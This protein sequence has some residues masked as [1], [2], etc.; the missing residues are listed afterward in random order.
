MAF[1]DDGRPVL[2]ALLMRRALE[3]AGMLGL[4]IIDHCEDPSLKGEGVAHEGFQAAALGLRGI[5]G[6]AES[7][8][9]E[10]DVSLAE[11][12]GAPVHVAHMSARQSIRAVRAGKERG[13]RVTCEVAP[14][15]FILTDEALAAPVQYDTNVKM[16]PPLREAADRDAM[17]RG[18]STAGWT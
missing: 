15:H 5:P 3:Y 4:P 9:V 8:M 12:T 17:F 14:H 1:S 6:V 10:R 18:S 13:I 16:N 2:T 11:I 7:M